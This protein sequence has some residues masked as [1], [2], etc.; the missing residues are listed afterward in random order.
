MN[1]GT[2]VSLLAT[3][4]YI[5]LLILLSTNRPWQRRQNLFAAFLAGMM[6][7]S[8]GTFLFRSDFFMDEKLLLAKVTLSF[9][10]LSIAPLHYFLRIYYEN[11][12]PG[13]PIAWVFS[14]ITIVII[15]L[16]LP[17]SVKF[18]N[19]PVPVYGP[20]LY[21]V[22]LFNFLLLG[23]DLFLIARKLGKVADPVVHNQ[24]VYLIAG[25]GIAV[26]II[27]STF[28]EMGRV[29]PMAQVGN[30]VFAL[31]LTYTVIRHRLL[32][33]RLVVRRGLAVLLMA[34]VGTGIYVLLFAIAH[35]LLN[36]EIIP[37]NLALGMGIALIIILVI[38]QIRSFTTIQIDKLFYRESYS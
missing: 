19:G 33:L 37:A 26:I 5:P 16:F 17:E 35:L 10:A 6:I 31:I 3:I 22:M 7:W 36:V 20:W 28:T 12:R 13:I 1:I 4:A 2:L 32:D 23:R 24:M 21:A 27:S 8:L 25:L 14:G 38:L 11:T 15:L 34:T 29:Y 30:F 18:E 9:L